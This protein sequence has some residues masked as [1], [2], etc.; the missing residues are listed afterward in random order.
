MELK[1]KIFIFLAGLTL[2]SMCIVALL[3]VY[4]RTHPGNLPMWIPLA[5]F[6]FLITTCVL[7]GVYLLRSVRRQAAV[8]TVAERSERQTSAAKGL[9]IGL[10]VWSLIFLNGIRLTLQH[11][12]PWQYAVPGL[13]FDFLLIVL[14]W[15]SLSRLR[16]A[17][18]QS[19]KQAA[20]N[21]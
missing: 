18:I 2:A 16:R 10:V 17:Q 3:V 14:F 5:M 4:V 8:E 19:V 13:A 6:A 12:V 11:T 20:P 7:G 1:K 21:S 9:K 15:R